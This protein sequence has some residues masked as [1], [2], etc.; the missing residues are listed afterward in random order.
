MTDSTLNISIIFVFLADSESPQGNGAP[1]GLRVGRLV[2]IFVGFGLGLFEGDKEGIIVGIVVGEKLGDSAGEGVG[3]LLGS[4]A[5]M[6]ISGSGDSKII[7]KNSEF[8]VND[9]VSSNMRALYVLSDEL[10]V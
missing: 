9:A 1:V 8:S 10:D 2:G 7:G 4:V 3:L 6:D 5:A